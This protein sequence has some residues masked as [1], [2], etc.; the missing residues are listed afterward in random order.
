MKFAARISAALLVSCLPLA[1]QVASH[2]P[3]P[4]K[5]AIAAPV[6]SDKPV[7]RVNGTVLTD[8]DLLRQMLTLFPYARQHGGRFPKDVEPELRK[9]ALREIE[10]EELAYQ[11]ALRR[12][13]T[14]APAKLQQ[15][16]VDF[17]KQ[18]SSDAEFQAYLKQEHG[19]TQNLRAKVRRAILIDQLLRTEINQKSR[20]TNVQLRAFYDK[21]PER[22]R[23]PESVS[24]QTISIALPE[25]ASADEKAAAR[26]RAEEALRQAKA[27]QNYEQFGMLAEKISE[28]DWRVMMGDHKW[29]HRGRM[30]AAVEKVVFSM[31]AGEVSGIIDTGDSFCIARVEARED[32]KL[33]PFADVRLKLKKDLEDQKGNELRAALDARLRKTAKV[34]EL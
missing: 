20:F 13:M 15:A 14:V 27:T 21:N 33:V 16:M 32:A 11:E 5:Q 3:T 25:K 4:I 28:D 2:A 19:T 1:G 9:K 26:K 34:E 22:F 24:L 8:R 10:F 31:K 30:P 12:N 6:P 29:L 7:A 18:F 23:K 17:K